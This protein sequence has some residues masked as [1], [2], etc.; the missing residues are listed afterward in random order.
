MVQALA[1]ADTVAGEELARL[2]VLRDLFAA[3]PN[4]E[5]LGRLIEQAGHD[6]ALQELAQASREHPEEDLAA[7]WMR[8]FEGPGRVPVVLFGSYYLDGEKL[9]GPSTQAARQ[10]YR[11]YGMEPVAN[12]P[13]DHLAYEL[14]LLGYFT[15]SA[16]MAD[17]GE[18]QRFLAARSEFV[19]RFMLPWITKMVK[20][21]GESTNFRF[22]VHLGDVLVSVI[23][24]MQ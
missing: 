11:Q 19:H 14:G 10:F 16:A 17:A 15:E 1:H 9:M 6:E 8:L 13:A 5:L 22:F 24:L 2:Q 18:R 7:E 21:L 3:A 20:V 23:Q 12:I 4:E